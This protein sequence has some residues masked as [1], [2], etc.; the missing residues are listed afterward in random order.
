MAA[1]GECSSSSAS[2][3]EERRSSESSSSSSGQPPS[4]LEKLKAPTPAAIARKRQ[5]KANPPPVGKRQCRGSS[6]SDPKTIQPSKRVKDF[7]NEQLK[8][9]GGK[10]FCSAYREELGL[11]EE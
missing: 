10:L 3:N 9:S 5:I 8:V 7:P 6:A 4:L 11:R 2:S 1:N